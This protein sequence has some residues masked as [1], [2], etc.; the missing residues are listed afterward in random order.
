LRTGLVASNL[1]ILAIV[2]AF[3]LQNPGTTSASTPL[4][5]DSKAVNDTVANPLD[6]LSSADIAQTVAQLNALPE[7]TA[8]T[9]Q[10]QSEA[11]DIAMASTSNNVISKPQVVATALKSRADIQSYTTVAG[12]TVT[13]VAAKFGVTTDSIRWSNSLSSS[14]ALSPGMHL[15]IP[16]VSGIVYTVKAGDT[17]ATLAIEF[18]ANADQITAYNDA[19][20]SGL[21]PGEQIIIPNATQNGAAAIAAIAGLTSG[22]S[23]AMAWGNGPVYGHNGYDFGN[24]TW[25][26]ANLIP[27]PANWG[28]ADTWAYYARLSGWAV[29]PT[30]SVGAIAQTSAGYFGHVALVKA[31][32]SDGSVTITEMN[33]AGFDV[34]DTRTVSASEFQNYI[35]H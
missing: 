3:V 30:P 14:D 19:E 26:V 27:V 18:N 15:T 32:N 33:H 23:G 12:D 31:V 4:A 21:T 5:A 28:N 6:Q 20:I 1:A 35:S 2:L 11:A 25:Y 17:P 22:S 10:A 13:S 24:C 34:I 7:T 29:K 8:V 16:P 9:N